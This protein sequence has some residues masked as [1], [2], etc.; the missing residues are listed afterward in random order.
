M[1]KFRS[2]K[3]KTMDAHFKIWE[4]TI[5]EI[6]GIILGMF[7][8]LGLIDCLGITEGELLDFIIDVDRGYLATF[9]HSFYHAADVTA[10]L[11]HILLDMNASQYLSKPEMAALLLAGLCHDIGHPGLNNLFQINAK[12]ELVKKYGEASVLETYSCSLAMDLVAKHRLFRN[13]SKSPAAILPEGN[14]ATEESMKASMIKAIMATDMSFHYDMLNNLNTLI[15]FISTPSSTPSSSDNETTETESEMDFESSPPPSPTQPNGTHNNTIPDISPSLVEAVNNIRPRFECTITRSHHRQS[16]ISSTSSESSDISIDSDGSTQTTRSVDIPRSPCDLTPELRQSFANCLLHA[17][18]ISNAVK[19]WEICKHWSDL[20]VQEFF[21]QGDIEKSQNLPVSPNMDR[22][23]HNQPQ[24]SLGFSDFVVQPYFET[25]VEFLPE[26]APFLVSLTSNRE[27]WALQKAAME[28][29]KESPLAVDATTIAETNAENQSSESPSEQ[30]LT[31]GRR[32]SVAAGVVILDDTRPQRP[33]L[34]RKLRHTTNMD[35]SQYHTVRKIKRSLSGRSL[36]TSLR[37]FQV[38]SPQPLLSTNLSPNKAVICT[39]AAASALRLEEA[40]SGKNSAGPKFYIGAQ[41]GSADQYL[42]PPMPLLQ[43]RSDR[44][45]DPP[46]LS[47]SDSDSA[48][49]RQRRH[50]SLQLENRHPSI[51]QEYGNGYVIL[52][53]PDTAL[54]SSCSRPDQDIN[55]K[56]IPLDPPHTFPTP[57]V[58]P[59]SLRSMDPEPP[60]ENIAFFHQGHHPLDERNGHEKLSPHPSQNLVRLHQASSRC[61]TPAV[62]FGSIH[63]DWAHNADQYGLGPLDMSPDASVAGLSGGQDQKQASKDEKAPLSSN[64]ETAGCIV[65]TPGLKSEEKEPWLTDSSISG[66]DGMVNISTAATG[67]SLTV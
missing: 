10:V 39:E 46:R 18:D 8:K 64:E 11:Y 25:F 30:P 24:I 62:L 66:V 37:D 7:V 12:T 23:Q 57:G 34:H 36:S 44:Q 20:V 26:A 58:W 6:Y 50:G 4:H 48:P 16:S 17:A 60:L 51:R 21:R 49:Y 9:Y 54:E 33:A 40:L 63:Y 53:H 31:S 61:S 47:Y 41:E 27:Q 52:N 67:L 19:P 15:E 55:T 32:V 42:L 56:H 38:N 5:P 65:G 2:G 59:T 14:H 22:A 1:L 3:F 43:Q 35:N 13:V 45:D 28:A 29:A